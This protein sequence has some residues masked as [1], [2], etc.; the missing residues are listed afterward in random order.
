MLRIYIKSTIKSIRNISQCERE[1]KLVKVDLRR[2]AEIG[3]ERQAQSRAKIIEAARLLFTSRPI[4]SVTVE[5]V[6]TRARRGSA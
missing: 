3:R 2:R 1:A 6:T 5:E 4:A